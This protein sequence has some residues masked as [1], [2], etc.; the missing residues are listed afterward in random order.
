MVASHRKRLPYDTAVE[1]CVKNMSFTYDPT[2]PTD[3]DRV[4]FFTSDKDPTK[5]ILTDE[6]IN[7][8]LQIE[9]NFYFAA[10]QAI[11]SNA[12]SY[13]TKA[14]SYSVGAGNN[15]SIRVDRRTILDNFLKLAQKLE[16]FGVTTPEEGFDRLDF[17]IDPFGRD[18]SEY[19]GFN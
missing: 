18:M 7:G 8:L 13:V 3:K 12:A 15:D 14:I 4:R 1:W 2:L 10:A 17:C 6:E 19:Q 5:I 11:R 9:P 16:D